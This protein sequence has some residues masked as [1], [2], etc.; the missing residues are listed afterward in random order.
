[1][2]VDSS[3]KRTEMPTND[4][5]KDRTYSNPRQYRVAPGVRYQAASWVTRAS[6]LPAFYVRIKYR[7]KKSPHALADNEVLVPKRAFRER[8]VLEDRDKW[9]ALVALVCCGFTLRVCTAMCSYVWLWLCGCVAVAVDVAACG[10]VAVCA[11]A[12]PWPRHHTWTHST[13]TC[14]TWAKSRP[15]VLHTAAFTTSATTATAVTG[16]TATL[17]LP[18][19]QERVQGHHCRTGTA[20]RP[21]PMRRRSASCQCSLPTRTTFPG[22]TSTCQPASC[23]SASPV[24]CVLAWWVWCTTLICRVCGCVLCCGYVC[25]CVCAA[26]TKPCTAHRPCLS[27]AKSGSSPPSDHSRWGNGSHRRQ[28]LSHEAPRP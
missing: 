26:A 23:L 25:G 11:C 13:S 3:G 10:C 21:A 15:T 28:T 9:T 20:T 27:C 2:L 7:E 14:P 8:Q 4:K 22:C 6:A 24:L 17:G 5:A 18:T 16:T 12:N 1:V 19:A